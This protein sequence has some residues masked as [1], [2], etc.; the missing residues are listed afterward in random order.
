MEMEIKALLVDDEEQCVKT[1]QDGIDW[2]VLGVAETFG[3]YNAV[4]AREIMKEES[5]MTVD[6][7]MTAVQAVPVDAMEEAEVHRGEAVVEMV[8]G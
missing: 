1:L 7:I 3:A 6:L 2:K 8:C 4:Q 5:W